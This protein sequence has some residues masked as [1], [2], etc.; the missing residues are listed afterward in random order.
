LRVVAP[1]RPGKKAKLRSD[2][3]LYSQSNTAFTTWLLYIRPNSAL[4]SL[5]I[6][7]QNLSRALIQAAWDETLGV[8]IRELGNVKS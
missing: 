7:L 1:C 6:V 5:Q 2:F 8:T 4:F 3:A